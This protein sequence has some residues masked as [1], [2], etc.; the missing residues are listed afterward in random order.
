MVA[1][2]GPEGASKDGA[3]EDAWSSTAVWYSSSSSGG[4]G[5]GLQTRN[6]GINRR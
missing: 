5:G 6:A 4:G 1:A 3:C 2:A